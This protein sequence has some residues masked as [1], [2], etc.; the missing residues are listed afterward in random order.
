MLPLVSVIVPVYNAENF[1]SRCV[2]S[3]IAQT[4]RNWELILVND[5][6]VDKSRYMCDRYSQQDSRIKTIHKINGGVTS[7]RAAGF[8]IS[9][10]E[11]LCFLDADD[12][13]LPSA[14]MTMFSRMTSEVD[15]VIP[16][17]WIDQILTREGYVKCLLENRIA[18]GV[19]GKM[20]RKYLF[21]SN[22]LTISKDFNI[23]EDLLMQ[24]CV[25]QD[26]TKKISLCR[27][28]VY[29]II[30]NPVS[31]TRSRIW[32]VDYE[33]KFITEVVTLTEGF[34]FNLVQQIFRL[35]INS[36]KGLINNNVSI[37]YSDSWFRHLKE[38]SMKYSLSME[39]K[40]LVNIKNTHLVRCL[41]TVK[42]LLW[43]IRNY[44]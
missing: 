9:R 13:L 18:W 31:A 15:I 7:A 19:V 14:L 4:Y 27:D 10:G 17:S 16:D 22:A 12:I 30:G 41:L 34:P 11:Y 36:L 5:G 24:L 29:K 21:N 32:S 23:G 3:V 2:D 42:E 8:R 43:K 6:S 37:D 20:F 26:L 1:I 40:I 38:D 44:R 39:E 33:L 28:E 35:R 25:A